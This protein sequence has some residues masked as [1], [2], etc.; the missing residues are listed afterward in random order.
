MTVCGEP[1]GKKYGMLLADV[2]LGVRRVLLDTR[3]VRR[4]WILSAFVR[5]H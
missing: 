4:T 1:V 3:M 5:R 2:Q